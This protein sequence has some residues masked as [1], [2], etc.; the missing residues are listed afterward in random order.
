MVDQNASWL[1]GPATLSV[2]MSF[3]TALQIGWVVPGS[4]KAAAPGRAGRRVG[5]ISSMKMVNPGQAQAMDEGSY[6]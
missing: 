3:S 1:T 5:Y 4:Y 6:A 2:S